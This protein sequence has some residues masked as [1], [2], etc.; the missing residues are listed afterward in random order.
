MTTHE[1]PRTEVHVDNLPT[2]LKALKQW[3]VWRLQADK[4]GKMTKVPYRP[5]SG[6]SRRRKASHSDA[7]TWDTFRQALV[8]WNEDVWYTGIGVTLANGLVGLDLD[9]FPRLRELPAWAAH[10]VSH[11]NTYTEWSPSGHG[12]HMLAWGK[13]PPGRRRTGPKDPHGIEMYDSHRFFTVTGDTL[14]GLGVVQERS[15]ELA[16]LH[17]EIFGHEDTD[18]APE[19]SRAGMRELDDEEILTLALNARNGPK[20]SRLF[21]GDA[22][23]YRRADGTADASAADLALCNLLAT[24]ARDRVQIDRLFRRSSLLRPKW[25][26]RHA[27]DGRTYGKMTIDRALASLTRRRAIDRSGAKRATARPK[28]DRPRKTK[29]YTDDYI[30]L[31]REWG[32]MVRLN[33]CNDD[34][35]VNGQPLTDLVE[36]KLRAR[37]RDYG[38]ANNVSVNVRHCMESLATFA[39]QNAHHP[40]KDY[41]ESLEWDGQ[42]HIAAV[43]GHFTDKEGLFARW[44]THWQVGAVAKVYAGFQNPMLVLDGPQDIGKSYFAAWLGSP[45]PH[46]YTTSAIYPDHKDHRLRLIQ[47]F[48]W[49]VEELGATT[50]RADVE[51]LKAFITLVSV[52]ERK[53]YGRRDII[54]PALAS[55]IGTINDDAGFLL[56]RTGN[57]RFLVCT[58]TR[59]DWSYSENVDVNQVWAQALYLYHNTDDWRLSDEDKE[60]R[61]TVNEDYMI[62]DPIEA[63]LVKLFRYTDDPNDFVTLPDVLDA[64]AIYQIRPTR[65]T[66]MA[67]ASGMRKWGAVRERR[68]IN[69]K[70]TRIYRKV[71]RLEIHEHAEIALRD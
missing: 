70:R 11:A 23:D 64:L 63:Y 42:D 46:M 65:T 22:S 38:T 60:R 13:L 58:L 2:Q 39:D 24:Y 49:E 36:A 67:V 20:F 34:V 5:Q 14:E 59:I 35:E 40:I 25:D 21:A 56:D 27:A 6:R 19:A 62:D 71:Q 43:A 15:A 50:R 55:F 32:Y 66:T 26:E 52:R 30:R 54:K 9:G 69:G 31:Y 68:R 29:L 8:C 10:L 37:V 16:A 53:A 48:V 51:A 47:T 57:R 45:L 3:V 17:T 41:L 18:K 1:I 44:Y 33:L 61:D 7:S 28:P 12:I 4:R